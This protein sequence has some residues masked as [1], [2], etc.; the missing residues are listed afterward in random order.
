MD[1]LPGHGLVQR[2]GCRQGRR[3]LAFRQAVHETR[4]NGLGLLAVQRAD[5][6]HGGVAR[7]V[8]APVEVAHL[9]HRQGADSLGRAA[10]HGGIRVCAVERG[11]ETALGNARRRLQLVLQADEHAPALALQFAFLETRLLQDRLHGGERLLQ[12]FGLGEAAQ[13][14]AGHVASRAGAELRPHVLEARGDGVGVPLAG[15][16][17]EQDAGQAR[18][19]RGIAVTRAAGIEENANVHHGQLRR[20]HEQHARALLR[21]PLLDGDAVDAALL[22]R[23]AFLAGA[24]P[25]QGDGDDGRQDEDEDVLQSLRVHC[26]GYS[27]P[28]C[29][30]AT[31]RGSSTATVR[32]SSTR[33]FFATCCS[34]SRVTARTRSTYS[35]ARCQPR[36]TVSSW[37]S[38]M[39]W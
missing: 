33:Y 7:H 18:K 32:P 6:G 30:P 22:R 4:G 2:R 14:D 11:V 5:D 34:C 37:P 28:A 31:G 25:Q 3:R 27:P 23:R 39:A 1:R 29:A 36:P 12:Q 17:I 8:I 19:P 9:F 35:S 20:G 10:R 15:A 21:G 16:V 13:A 26:H 24:L 38:C